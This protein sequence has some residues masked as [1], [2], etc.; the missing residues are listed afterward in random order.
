MR[1]WGTRAKDERRSSISR[2]NFLKSA[3]DVFVGQGTER[4]RERRERKIARSTPNLFFFHLGE[5]M[6]ADELTPGAATISRAVIGPAG[7]GACAL[8][9]RSRCPH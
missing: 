8:A 1:M 4:E 6:V 5:V 2:E 7:G 9:A 3:E